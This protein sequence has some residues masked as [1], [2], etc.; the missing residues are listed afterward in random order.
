MTPTSFTQP[1]LPPSRR[2]PE[3]PP[4]AALEALSAGEEV[5]GAVRAHA[6]RCPDCAGQLRALR[7]EAEAFVR[8][9][10]PELFLRQ[11][12]RREAAARERPP[13]FRR[14][15]P[16]L[17][18][19]VPA[20]LAVVFLPRVL[21]TGDRGEVRLKG[22]GFRVA[23]AHGGAGGTIDLGASDAVVRPGDALRFA[24]EA[25]RDGHLLVLNLDGRGE[26]SVL[27]PFGAGASAPLAAGRREFLPG[28]VV[29]DDAPGPE[30]L[31]AV[32]SL[33]PLEAAPLLEELRRQAGRPEPALSCEG[34]EVTVLRLQRGP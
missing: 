26:A 2:G 19:A 27:H 17:A 34:C 28:S 18:L 5:G 4:A 8:A 24:Y 14:L 10:P 21:H 12:A 9:R 30:L 25:E 3:C 11:L 13:L 6:G 7:A 33:R 23:V 29:L 1:P 16:V 20:V 32:F 31:V 15:L 22:P